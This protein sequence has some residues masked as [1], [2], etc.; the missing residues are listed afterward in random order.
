MRKH[1]MDRLLKRIKRWSEDIDFVLSVMTGLDNPMLQDLSLSMATSMQ[2]MQNQSELVPYSSLE[3]KG[4]QDIAAFLSRTWT[5]GEDW[6][7]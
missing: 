6:T 5:R 7:I 2:E 4:I 1:T 3:E